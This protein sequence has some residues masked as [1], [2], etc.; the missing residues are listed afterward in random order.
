MLCSWLTLGNCTSL[1]LQS[2]PSRE[3]RLGQVESKNWTAAA[4]CLYSPGLC[5]HVVSHLTHTHTHTHC[6]HLPHAPTWRCPDTAMAVMAP[7]PWTCY[8]SLLGLPCSGHIHALR[9]P[10]APSHGNP[11]RRASLPPHHPARRRLPKLAVCQ[12]A[13]AT[14]VPVTRVAAPARAW[15]VVSIW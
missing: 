1:R 15:Y 7:C 14:C 3:V 4:A 10:G 5:A 6:L 8:F 12:G 9:Y 11:R 13:G 2:P